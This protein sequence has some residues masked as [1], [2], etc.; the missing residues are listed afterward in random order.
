MPFPSAWLPCLQALDY[1]QLHFFVLEVIT[2]VQ[3]IQF[4][5]VIVLLV[6]AAPLEYGSHCILLVWIRVLL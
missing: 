6:L 5:V 3:V 1:K 2:W 4:D